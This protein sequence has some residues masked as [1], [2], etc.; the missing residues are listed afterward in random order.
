MLY[1]KK[2]SREIREVRGWDLVIVLDVSLNYTS[3]SLMEERMYIIK[4]SGGGGFFK[5]KEEEM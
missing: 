5:Y 1:R 2:S 3:G 4:I